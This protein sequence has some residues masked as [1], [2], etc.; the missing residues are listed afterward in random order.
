MKS[1]RVTLVGCGRGKKRY[2]NA[3]GYSDPTAGCA[4]EGSCSVYVAPLTRR[5]GE[6][7]KII[8]RRI[9]PVSEMGKDLAA[10]GM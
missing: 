10:L 5:P 4:M 1:R 9:H 3:E 6:K 2:Y 8:R 7:E